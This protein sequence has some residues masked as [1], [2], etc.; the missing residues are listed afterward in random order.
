MSLNAYLPAYQLKMRLNAKT[1]LLKTEKY[2][3]KNNCY[4]I[5][6]FFY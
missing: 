1:K 4:I 3:I 2:D 5:K 6:I